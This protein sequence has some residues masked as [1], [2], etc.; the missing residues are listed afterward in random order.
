MLVSELLA[1]LNGL[2]DSSQAV[3]VRVEGR[4]P[5]R[6]WVALISGVNVSQGRVSILLRERAARNLYGECEGCGV[7]TF[8]GL[9]ARRLDNGGLMCFECEQE[10]N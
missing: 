6:D 2:D 4:K 7:D 3:Q 10:E 9:E 5:G 1:L 8:E